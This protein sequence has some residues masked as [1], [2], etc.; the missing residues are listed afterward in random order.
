MSRVEAAD[1]LAWE[2]LNQ[3]MED[4]TVLDVTVK[5]VVNA[6][7]IAYVEGIRGFIPPPNC[8]SAMWKIST[9]T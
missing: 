3:Y 8:L 7:V 4:K 9:N 1:D 6:G 5:G 2:K